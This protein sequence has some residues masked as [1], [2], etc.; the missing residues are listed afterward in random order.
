MIIKKYKAL[1]KES[2]GTIEITESE[3]AKLANAVA[4]RNSTCN[5][6]NQ[7]VFKPW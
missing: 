5:D 4:I 6:G 2:G 3:R 1:A 7:I